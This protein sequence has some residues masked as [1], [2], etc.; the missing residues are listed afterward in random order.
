MKYV[1]N[2]TCVAIAILWFIAI[3]GY[4]FCCTM[5]QIDFTGRRGTPLELP[6]ILGVLTVGV[7]ILLVILYHKKMISSEVFTTSVIALLA[8]LGVLVWAFFGI[9]VVA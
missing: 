4:M 6:L 2:I 1:G 3:T 9:L 7:M 5:G 8:T